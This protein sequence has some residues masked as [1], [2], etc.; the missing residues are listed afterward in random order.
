MAGTSISLLRGDAES[1]ADGWA[2]DSFE[3]RAPGGTQM[4]IGGKL[5]VADRKVAFTGP[6]RI[7]S[8]DPGVFFAWIEGRAAAGRAAVGPM[9]G[10]RRAHPRQ[11]AHR[12]RGSERRASTTSRWRGRPPTASRPLPRR[13]AS[14]RT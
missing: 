7:D 10:K 2:I 8:T 14:M 4:R 9:R 1:R 6:V 12:G 11:R 13:R 5:A 3:W